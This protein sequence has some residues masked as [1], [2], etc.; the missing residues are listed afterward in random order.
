MIAV[1]RTAPRIQKKT[2]AVGR[3]RTRKMTSKISKKLRAKK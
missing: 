1:M 3:K 2:A